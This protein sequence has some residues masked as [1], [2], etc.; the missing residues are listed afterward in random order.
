MPGELLDP[1]YIC[2]KVWVSFIRQFTNVT[3]CNTVCSIFFV[4]ISV[5]SREQNPKEL[6]F[7]IVSNWNLEVRCN[8]IKMKDYSKDRPMNVRIFCLDI[9]HQIKKTIQKQWI[10]IFTGF[11][12]KKT[13]FTLQFWFGYLLLYWFFIRNNLIV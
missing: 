6:E 5:E 13:S 9:L 12:P 11:F 1:A 4:V 2:F 10:W 7:S 8:L 3:L